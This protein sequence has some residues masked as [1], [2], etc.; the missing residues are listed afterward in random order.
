MIPK[1]WLY[2]KDVL[3]IRVI[4]RDT[5]EHSEIL[6]FGSEGLRPQQ[7]FASPSDAAEYQKVLE[8]EILARGYEL[9][10]DSQKKTQ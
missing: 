8:A 2:K 6:V 1:V 10:W 7:R 5:T 4:Q 9:T 3:T